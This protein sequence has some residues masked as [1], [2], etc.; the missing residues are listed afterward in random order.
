MDD[1]ELYY[2]DKVA[3]L[4]RRDF[5]RQVGHTVNGQ[6]IPSAHF[7]L[8]VAQIAD[9]L[10]LHADDRLLDVCCGNGLFTQRLAAKVHSVV[11]IDIA[12]GLIDI[13][14]AD[15]GGANISYLHMDAREVESLKAN[16]A[17][18]FDKVVLYAALQHF[19]PDEFA[20]VFDGLK[21]L[22]AP[23]GAIMLGFV[24]DKALIWDFYNT[25]QR[26]AE[27]LQRQADGTDTFG[28]WWPRP[29]LD[30]M[31]RARAL[32]CAFSV[33]PSEVHASAY[34]FNAVVRHS[35]PT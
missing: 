13:A 28:F 2:R 23:E 30:R 24:P 32:S 33:L 8:L 16:G 17:G 25:P 26:R 3:G 5:F 35:P 18:A 22:L 19:S 29:T 4:D 21:A 1:W 10:D 15:H 34:R 14:G 27:H 6:P 20:P 7:D 11:G 12:S 9:T 31:C